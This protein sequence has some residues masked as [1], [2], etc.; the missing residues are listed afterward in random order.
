VY[1]VQYREALCVYST[2]FKGNV[3]VL[4]NVFRVVCV[5]HSIERQYICNIQYM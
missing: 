5:L 3:F 4:Y 1:N 2:L